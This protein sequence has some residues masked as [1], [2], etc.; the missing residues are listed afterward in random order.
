MWNKTCFEIQ[1]IIRLNK[2]RR[3]QVLFNALFSVQPAILRTPIPADG[4]YAIKEA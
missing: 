4:E 3:E 2:L 1:P